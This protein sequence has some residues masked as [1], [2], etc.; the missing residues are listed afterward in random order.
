MTRYATVIADPGWQY[1]DKMAAMKSTGNGAASKYKVES[2]TEILAFPFLNG[3]QIADD[4]HL[5]LWTTNAFIEQAHNVARAWGF[6]PKTV[7]TWVKGRIANGVLVQH[8]GQGHYL[9]NSTEHVVFAVRG[10]APP[11]LRNIPTAFVYPGRWS[12]RKHSE[13]PPIIH[14]WAEKLWVGPRIELYAR[15]LRP[16]WNAIGNEVTGGQQ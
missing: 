3:I 9:R 1:R 15:N 4:A 5:W 7:V 11:A 14:E 8:V 6:Q 10:K 12:G 16:G 13:K 2:L